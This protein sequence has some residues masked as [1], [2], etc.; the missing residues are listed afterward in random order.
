MMKRIVH[1]AY[2][3]CACALFA[4]CAEAE[5]QNVDVGGS[6]EIYGAYYSEFFADRDRLVWPDFF[7]PRRAIGPTGTITY[8]D[9]DRHGPNIG[10][11]EQ[12]TKL[13]LRADFTNNVAAFVELDGVWNW[14]DDFRSD[15]RSGLDGR[16]AANG[17]PSVFQAYIEAN[18]LFGVPARLRVGRQTLAFGHE[19]LVGTNSDPDPFI[20]VSFDA[21]R[22]TIGDG[23]LTADLWAAKLGEGGANEQDGDVDFYG[24]Y[25]TWNAS[26][27]L[28]IDAYYMF[29][30]DARSINDTNF[31]API[32]WLEGLAGLDNY[33]STALHTAGLAVYGAWNQFDY[34][35]EA[36][37]QW[38]EADA[39]GA[40]FRFPGQIYG[41]DDARFDTFGGVFELG[42]TFDVQ[43]SPRVFV[44]GA[45]FG[46]DDRRDTSLADFVNPFAR[47]QASVSFNRL[48]SSYRPTHFLD[49]SAL[50]NFWLLRAGIELSVT[51]NLSVSLDVMNYRV[52]EPFDMP[53]YI[54]LGDFRIPTAPALPFLTKQGDDDLGIEIMLAPT[55]AYSEDL[56]FSMQLVYHFLGD[57]YTDGVF[58]DEN[59]TRFIGGTGNEDAVSATFLMSL[60]F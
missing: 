19:W 10:F 53:H 31:A 3:Y 4:W 20:E 5:L 35:A 13:N 23:P 47:P 36:A 18:D 60:A 49:Y 40:Q 28:A 11:V 58:L 51:D 22:L 14:G 7:L 33:D 25:T 42:Y 43:L 16:A 34:Y 59:G 6:I 27:V 55:Y 44:A 1:G 21:L 24:V 17:D 29:L 2:R 57:A 50:S 9:N 37:Y 32:E 26:E 38:G 41:D 8:V 54:Q 48:F 12:R 45:Y 15:Y 56:T 52:V 30:R 39:L 46:S